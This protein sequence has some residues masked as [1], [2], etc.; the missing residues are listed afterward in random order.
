MA[1]RQKVSMDV[2]NR[3]RVGNKIISLVQREILDKKQYNQILNYRVANKKDRD[4]KLSENLDRMRRYTRV[5]YGWHHLQKT[6]Q[7]KGKSFFL[8]HAKDNWQE[9]IAHPQRVAAMAMLEGTGNCQ[10]NAS[11]TYLLLRS[12]VSKSDLVCY[13]YAGHHWYC[14]V[15]DANAYKAWKTG[16]GM[17]HA[18]PINDPLK[19]VPDDAVIVDPWI[20]RSTS[21]LWMNSAHHSKFND[22]MCIHKSGV[23]DMAEC[24]EANVK[25]WESQARSRKARSKFSTTDV[26]DIM[27]RAVLNMTKEQTYMAELQRLDA[28]TKETIFWNQVSPWKGKQKREYHVPPPPLPSKKNRSAPPEIGRKKP[29][30]QANQKFQNLRN[31]WESGRVGGKGIVRSGSGGRRPPT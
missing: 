5:T 13:V 16:S 8:N 20:L 30:Q 27:D 21:V 22:H 1:L 23:G 28:L 31:A 12:F 19:Q 2:M 25:K 29:A 26:L 7:G 3:I 11:I 24:K 4:T 10:E 6:G 9:N 17:Y 18:I 14:M 15:V